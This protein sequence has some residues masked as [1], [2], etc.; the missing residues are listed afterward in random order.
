MEMGRREGPLGLDEVGATG[1]DKMM[2]Y[3]ELLLI[4]WTDL[5]K[6]FIL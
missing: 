4:I 2:C 3:F 5:G 1:L 6:F